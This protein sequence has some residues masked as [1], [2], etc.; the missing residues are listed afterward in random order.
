MEHDVFGSDAADRIQPSERR[1]P[2][3]IVVH[4]NAH[5]NEFWGELGKG[6]GGQV[7]ETTLTGCVLTPIEHMVRSGKNGGSVMVDGIEYVFAV[8]RDT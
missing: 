3:C 4:V 6:G 7:M 2:R 8:S 5:G 1:N